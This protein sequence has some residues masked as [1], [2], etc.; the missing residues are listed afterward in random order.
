MANQNRS[1]TYWQAADP[2]ELTKN[3]DWFTSSMTTTLSSSRR[4]IT[5]EN[6][7]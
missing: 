4:A 7:N 3:T 5:T 6:D 1:D 2:D